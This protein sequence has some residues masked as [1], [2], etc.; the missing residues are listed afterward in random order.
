MSYTEPLINQ[1]YRFLLSLGFGVLMSLFYEILSC[2]FLIVSN[3]KKSVFARDI[4]FSVVFTVLSFFFMLVYNEGVVRFNLIFGHLSGLAVFH[5]TFGKM[6][7]APFLK[8]AG[9]N[10]FKFKS[11]K[12]KKNKN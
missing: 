3:G 6:I 2:L 5:L 4:I 12:N 11:K 7:Q 8:F 10:V 9:R 1:I